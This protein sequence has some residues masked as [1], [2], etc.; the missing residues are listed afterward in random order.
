MRGESPTMWLITLRSRSRSRRREVLLDQPGLLHGALDDD[1]ERVEIE[2][3]REVVLGA[4]FDGVDGAADGA[5]SRHHDEHR[6][7][8]KLAAFL[9]EPDAV[10]AGHLE[11]GEHDVGLELRQLAER[12]ES[13]R[14]GFSDVTVFV[15]NLAQARRGRWLRRPR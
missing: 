9:H 13:V 11:I 2:R 5:E 10:E 12:F 15:Q 14:R 6:A 8:E 7:R 1:R 3:L 4:A